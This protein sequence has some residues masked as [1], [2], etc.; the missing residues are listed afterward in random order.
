[1]PERHTNTTADMEHEKK[2]KNEPSWSSIVPYLISPSCS[3]HG[4]LSVQVTCLTVFFHNLCPSFLWSTSLPHL[5]R[6]KPYGHYA[7]RSQG[8]HLDIRAQTKKADV[9]RNSIM[10]C[11]TSRVWRDPLS[12]LDLTATQQQHRPLARPVQQTNK[13]TNIPE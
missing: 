11:R 5:Q 3:I 8:C 10:N 6:N 2:N 9:S 7:S 13:Q 12:R 4:I 1:L